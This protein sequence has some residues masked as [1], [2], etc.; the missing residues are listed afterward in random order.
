MT[1]DMKGKDDITKKIG[2]PEDIAREL[3]SFRKSAMLPSSRSARLINTCENQ[4][5]AV[6]R[7]ETVAYGDT[8]PQVLE[9]IDKEG[10]PRGDVA[11]RYIDRK[12]RTLICSRA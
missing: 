2:K 5:I 9:W 3:Q 4:W 1:N 11:V 8:L 6:Y 12:P 10:I 7:G